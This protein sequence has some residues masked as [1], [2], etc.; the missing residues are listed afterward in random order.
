MLVRV[1]KLCWMVR[2]YCRGMSSILNTRIYLFFFYSLKLSFI[3]DT[4]VPFWILNVLNRKFRRLVGFKGLLIG[5]WRF[6][7]SVPMCIIYDTTWNIPIFCVFKRVFGFLGVLG[8]G[9]I[10]RAG[11]RRFMGWLKVEIEVWGYWKVLKLWRF[12]RFRRL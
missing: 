6:R 4:C 7:K 8:R 1:D 9:L 10:V 2:M 5:L 3:F 11:K 12:G